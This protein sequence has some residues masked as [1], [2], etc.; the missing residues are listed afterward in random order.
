MALGKITGVAAFE[1][2]FALNVIAF[3]VGGGL[4]G[5]IVG[6]FMTLLEERLPFGGAPLRG[7]LIST[8]FWL[9]LRLGGQLHSINNP[10]RYHSD[11]NQTVAGFLFAVVL[12]LVL[13]FLW[14]KDFF[15][16]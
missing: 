11:I 6:G 15:Q 16:D 3:A 12:G 13:G 14:K 10:R 2:G 5:V 1:N 4:F 8:S 9:I 7:F